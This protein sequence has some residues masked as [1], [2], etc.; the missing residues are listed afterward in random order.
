MPASCFIRWL[1]GQ[2][3][4]PHGKCVCL[5]IATRGTASNVLSGL[6]P[7]SY[8]E[9]VLLLVFRLFAAHVGARS[10]C[11]RM[12]LGWFSK[13]V[14]LRTVGELRMRLSHWSFTGRRQGGRSGCTGVCF[15]FIFKPRCSLKITGI[16]AF[17]LMVGFELWAVTFQ[18]HGKL[19]FPCWC[20]EEKSLP[21]L[22]K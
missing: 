11:S 5:K 9:V 16:L 2:H 6:K 21:R 17:K 1:S 4:I 3:S 15:L 13:L 8:S 19:R 14:L 12:L 20:R 22:L 10:S 7:R 18:L